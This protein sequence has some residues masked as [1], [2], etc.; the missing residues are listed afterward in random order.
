[1]NLNRVAVALNVDRTTV[2]RAL[3]WIK[4]KQI[5]RPNKKED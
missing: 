5:S 2:V 3:R 4:G 1:M